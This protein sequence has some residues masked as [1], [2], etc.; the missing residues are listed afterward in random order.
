MEL[1]VLAHSERK[2]ILCGYKYH[3]HLYNTIQYNLKGGG[4]GKKKER[5]GIKNNGK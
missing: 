2:V 1:K 5:K 3:I 4:T